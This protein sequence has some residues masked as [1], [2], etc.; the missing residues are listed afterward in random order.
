MKYNQHEQ[1]FTE[2]TPEEGAMIEGGVSV[3]LIRD[4]GPVRAG[5]P[6]QGDF[7]AFAAP[8]PTLLQITN[9]TGLDLSYDLDFAG[10]PNAGDNLSIANGAVEDFNGTAGTAI[11][12]WD[13]MLNLPE[14]QNLSQDLTPGR[15]YEF[16]AAA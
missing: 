8:N 7:R 16:Y 14:G 2:L 3:V 11:A 5:A 15:R 10:A 1:L 13:V 6:T 12:T 9:S 4:V